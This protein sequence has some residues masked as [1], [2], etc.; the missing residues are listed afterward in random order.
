MRK[1]KQ[2]NR[3][4]AALLACAMVGLTACGGGSA[5]ST[6]TTAAQTSDTTAAA[7]GETS[8]A[9]IPTTVVIGVSGDLATLDPMDQMSTSTG[10]F[11]KSVGT[12]L[13]KRDENF[14]LVG[15]AATGYEQID[16]LTWRFTLRDDINFINGDHM[17]ADDV[18]FSLERVAKDESLVANHYF[19]CIDHVDVVDEYTVDVVTTSP[20]PDMLSLVAM[21]SSTILPKNW[22]EENGIDAYIQAP[23][24]SGQYQLKEWIPDDHYTL[25][26]NPDYYGEPATW[27]E[28]T[29]RIIPESSTRVA[30]LMTGGVDII[31]N[32]P[33]NEWERVSGN[34]EGDGTSLVYG[35]TSSILLMILKL[36]EGRVCS[37]PAVREAIELAIDKEAICEQLL[38]GAGTPTRTRIASSVPGH[39]ESLFGPENGNLYDPEK[40][41]QILADAGY[42]E[43][44]LT[45]ELTGSNNRYLMDNE[46][47]QM[48]A[49]Y[50]EAIGIHVNLE[51]VDSNVLSN[52]FSEKNIKDAFLVALSDGQYDGC[53]PLAQFC[54]P[55]RTEGMSDWNNPTAV[56]LY[57][58]TR[59]EMDEAKKYELS[60]QI[61]E[62]CAEER[63]QI[64]I[65]QLKAIFGV[66][67]RFT[68][69]P[70][71]DS[72][73]L[74]GEISAAQ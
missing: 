35:E 64:A 28:V 63:P 9:E 67:N 30:E 50:I 72:T 45:L 15:D 24:T 49:A 18:K 27:E 48:I 22:F 2:L 71:M 44:E 61:Q 14:E 70:Q 33:V 12:Q 73:V 29:Y 54:D 31:T 42:Q 13:Y 53:Y 7:A 59:S 66:N 65:A 68:F 52:M 5:A 56:E 17:T 3:L 46:I 57:Q 25:I 43:G 38:Q 32:V 39:D 74:P 11:F 60:R 40:A 6:E 21:G 36:T 34:T 19:N 16:D 41:K 23:V 62:I 58:Q 1:T 37:D 20:R 47:A 10:D 51:I 69:S 8:A 26:P 4:T 55:V